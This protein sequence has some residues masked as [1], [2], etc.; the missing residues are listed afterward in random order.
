MPS[1]RHNVI[2]TGSPIIY[3]VLDTAAV[4]RGSGS[5]NKSRERE[6]R[7]KI[8]E[9]G[10]VAAVILLPENLFYNTGAPAIILI[11]DKSRSPQDPIR[12]VNAS[13]LFVKGQP[14]NYLAPEHID[15]IV[16][17]VRSEHDIE[18]LC[19]LVTIDILSD[20][21]FDLGPRRH[22][23][24]NPDIPTVPVADGLPA[25]ALSHQHL[26]EARQQT[27]Q[28][29]ANFHVIGGEQEALPQGWK[30][31]PLTVVIAEKLSG[32]WGD[33][34]PTRG[35]PA[36][37]CAVIRG[38]DFPDVG[39]LR[40]AE[41]PI[42]YISEKTLKARQPR[43]GDILVEISGGGKYQ[44]TGR[45]LYLTD[46]MFTIANDPVMFTNFTKLLRVDDKVIRPKYFYYQWVHL[47]DLGRTAIYEKQPTNIKNFKLDD[48]LKSE[49]ISFPLDL[50]Q[51][52]EI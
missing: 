22:V 43:V 41:V 16:N 31:E 44:N 1:G 29:L 17:A 14:K 21:D 3:V 9:D 32:D 7:Q 38:T 47:Y 27:T 46:E 15:A 48:F 23:P 5:K 8:V 4:S 45:A 51:F 50:V 34:H 12:L 20:I 36:V 28:L 6:I 19:R 18:D 10:L 25:L 2:S 37:R 11:L 24:I 30:R 35:K 33:E 52:E 42:R 26:E 49:Y 40:F 13:R 39:R